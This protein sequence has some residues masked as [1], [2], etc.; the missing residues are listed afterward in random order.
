M[1]FYYLSQPLERS[2]YSW[3]SNEYWTP[4]WRPSTVPSMMQTSSL[5]A[6]NR[7]TPFWWLS[8]ETMATAA[9][10]GTVL[11]ATQQHV[12]VFLMCTFHCLKPQLVL[13]IKN[14]KQLIMYPPKNRNDVTGASSC[15]R[16]N[17]DETTLEVSEWTTALKLYCSLE[18]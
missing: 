2:P 11:E 14:L 3:M 5:D 12:V 10:T 1:T 18:S 8:P 13:N 7:T 17:I 9:T 16:L 15:T 6:T 4:G